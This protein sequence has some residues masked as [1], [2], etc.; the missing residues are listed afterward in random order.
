MNL[1]TGRGAEGSSASSCIETYRTRV[2]GGVVLLELKAEPAE[3]EQVQK[4]QLPDLYL[5]PRGMTSITD[6]ASAMDA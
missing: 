4:Q 5:Q 3:A 1:E 6:C 2:E